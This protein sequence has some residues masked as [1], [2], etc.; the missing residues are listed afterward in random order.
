MGNM[1]REEVREI[2]DASL[3]GLFAI[4]ADSQ[5][6]ETED[7]EDVFEDNPEEEKYVETLRHDIVELNTK[8]K[9]WKKSMQ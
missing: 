1:T 9:V 3:A 6:V 2:G 4:Q 7:D 5:T 8:L